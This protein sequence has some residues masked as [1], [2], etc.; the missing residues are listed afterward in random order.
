[1]K[2]L[3]LEDSKPNHLELFK[4]EIHTWVVYETQYVISACKGENPL[5]RGLH[6]DYNITAPYG[7]KQIL[8]G[9]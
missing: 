6:S 9:I 5:Q 1:M 7:L 2:G 8:W 4:H 3:S